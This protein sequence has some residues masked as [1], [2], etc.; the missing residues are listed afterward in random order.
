MTNDVQ[1]EL[2]QLVANSRRQFTNP[3]SSITPEKLARQLAEFRAGTLRDF[4]LTADAIEERDDTLA[5]VIPKAKAAVARHGFE[6]CVLERLPDGMEALAEKQKEAL[7]HF[8]N[9]LRATSA[10]EPDE[11]GGFSLLVRQMMDAKAKRYA[12]HHIIW[13]PDSRGY[14]TATMIHVPLWFFENRTGPLRFIRSAYGY[15]G[16]PLD[17][18]AWLVSVGDGVMRACAA[19]WLFKRLPLHSWVSYSEKHGFPLVLGKTSAA[20]DSPEWQAMVDAVESISEDWS[21][22]I[23]Q[24]AAIELIEAKG[25]GALPY[26]PLVER[27]DRALV[28]LWRGGDLGTMSKDGQAVG[29]QP[30][31]S[32]T[33]MVDLD[34]ATWI[35]ETLQLKLD[36]LIL[37]NVFG[38]DSPALA[39]VKV[40]TAPKKE[41]DL[42]LKV[43]AFLLSAGHPLSKKQAA[44]RYNRPLPAD[45][46]QE[47][48]DLLTAPRPAP[49]SF[50]PGGGFNAGQVDR[51]LNEAVRSAVSDS[52]FRAS[53]AREIIAA[54]VKAFEPLRAQLE[55][56]AGMDDETA[57]D[58]KA[59]V[60][61]ELEETKAGNPAKT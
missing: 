19:A 4:A 17:T 29:S 10:L 56:I 38:E 18:G 32:E 51:A 45:D 49:S 41:T 58:I 2:I 22:V 39:Y 48:G 47:D 31:D 43:D 28:R 60:V 53:S 34:A 21:G 3:I 59:A 61:Y 7:E 8:Y 9:N 15:D 27:M 1:S 54:K 16:E 57:Q 37:D 13:K 36:R 46:D 52:A 25:A 12:C 26:P 42:D 55:E 33:T 11:L 20:K 14:Y 35:S 5:G 40:K 44:E 24:E 23:S 6:V 30:Q 50:S